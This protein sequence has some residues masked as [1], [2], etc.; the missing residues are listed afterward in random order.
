L[1]SRVSIPRE[2]PLS[3]R[4]RLLT[5]FED[6]L[7]VPVQGLRHTYPG[8]HQRAATFGRH[9]QHFDRD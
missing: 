5:G 9:D 3:P 6:A 8:M 1:A 7:N 4:R 2:L